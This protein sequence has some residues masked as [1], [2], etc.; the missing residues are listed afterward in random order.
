MDHAL[1][2]V[3]TPTAIAVGTFITKALVHDTTTPL[4]EWT[5]AVVAGG[6]AAGIIQTFMGMT[7]LSSTA[8]TGGFGNGVVSTIEALGAIVLSALAIFVPLFAMSLVVVLLIFMLSKGIQLLATRRQLF[9]RS[10]ENK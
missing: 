2:V 3:S 10:P 8:L 1:D 9:Q 5:V 6:G 4:L 7:R